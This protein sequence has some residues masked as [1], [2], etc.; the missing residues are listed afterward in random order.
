[1]TIRL[2]PE[3]LTRMPKI[4]PDTEKSGHPYK[5][6]PV[7]IETRFQNIPLK[8]L[9]RPTTSYPDYKKSRANKTE[10]YCTDRKTSRLNSI[11]LGPADKILVRFRKISPKSRKMSTEILDKSNILFMTIIY[12]AMINFTFLQIEVVILST[13]RPSMEYRNPSP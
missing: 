1:M 6:S 10:K 2:D 12:K 3:A 4:S 9:S 7:L 13:L 11:N 5:F 8:L